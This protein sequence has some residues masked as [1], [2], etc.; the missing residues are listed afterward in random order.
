M[1]VVTWIESIEFP[2]YPL[3]QQRPTMIKSYLRSL[4]IGP[5]IALG[6]LSSLPAQEGVK[7]V[8]FIAGGPSHDYGSHEHYAGCR[9]LADAIQKSMPQVKC[10]IIR[11]GWPKEDQI[12]DTA[13]SIVIY[14]DGGGGHPANKHLDRLEPLMK[15]G[16][17]FV[18]LHYGVEVP[19]GEVGDKFLQWLGGYF[20]THWSVNPHWKADFKSFP[21]HPIARGASPFQSQDE[22]YFHMRF[23]PDMKGVTPIL[24]ESLLQAPWSGPMVP[25]AETRMSGAVAKGEPQHTAWAYDRPGGGRSFGFTGGHYHWN[26]GQPDTLRLVSNAI[27]WTTGVDSN[28]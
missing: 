27:V 14:S 12:L 7:R 16:V 19:K 3:R 11:N 21:N 4:C 10:E 5:F 8:V 22:W 15:K 1:S 28:T 24:S 25:T 2:S 13:D 26:W 20:E 23:Q 18:C 17:G 6:F 9:I